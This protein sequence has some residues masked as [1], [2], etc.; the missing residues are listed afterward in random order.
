MKTHKKLKH[1]NIKLLILDVDGVLTD[2]KI[3][4]SDNGI[5]TK[6][7]NIQDGLGLKLLLN[8]AINVAVISG[9]KSNAT[10][11]RVRELG[12]KH[13]YFGVAD[14]IKIFNSLKKKL[15]LKNENIACI[16]DDLPDLPII[17][18]VG[19]SIAVANAVPEIR[20]IV[21]Y[22]TKNKGGDGAVREACDMI[23]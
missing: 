2:G 18:Q 5:E 3:Y 23:L 9:R 10:K 14:K 11:I 13:A 16:G 7:F 21:D 4:I 15:C 8:N 6:S 19:F 20:K 1:L 12:I 17:Q 22:T